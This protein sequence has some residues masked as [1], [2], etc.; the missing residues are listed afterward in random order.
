MDAPTR[1]SRWW[2]SPFAWPTIS[3]SNWPLEPETAGRGRMTAPSPR[4]GRGRRLRLGLVAVG[5][6]LGVIVTIILVTQAFSPSTRPPPAPTTPPTGA[7]P[8]P[9]AECRTSAGVAIGVDD[10]GQDVVNAHPPGTT[11]VIRAGTHLR[12]F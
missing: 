6:V 5:C 8:P 11:Y 7:P 9:G 1:H 4:P 3:R 10:D 2:R 12:N